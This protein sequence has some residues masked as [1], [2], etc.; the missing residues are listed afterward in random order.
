MHLAE[1]CNAWLLARSRSL[2][3]R[4]CINDV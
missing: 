4:D 1:V 2:H 3:Y